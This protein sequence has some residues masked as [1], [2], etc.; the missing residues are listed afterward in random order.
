L[1]KP[2]NNNEE[3]NSKYVAHLVKA[4][5]IELVA[6]AAQAPTIPERFLETGLGV[7]EKGTLRYRCF[8][9]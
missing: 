7:S 4:W 8:A 5:V 2:V 9:M 1:V 6:D 3:R